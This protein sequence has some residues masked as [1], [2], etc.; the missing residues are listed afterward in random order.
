MAQHFT[1]LGY[2]VLVLD[3]RGSGQSEHQGGFS[4]E[5]MADDI[6]ALWRELG[7]S[8]TVLLGISMGGRICQQL[9]AQA[10]QV[11]SHLILV[12]TTANGDYVLADEDRKWG[13]DLSAIKQTMA[14]YFSPKFL[15][16]NT[17]LVDAMAKNIF[18][19]VSSGSFNEGAKAQDQALRGVDSTGLL[20]AFTLPTL[21][22]HGRDDQIIRCAAAIHLFDHIDDSELLLMSGIGHLLLA[23]CPKR[24]YAEV[25]RFI[26]SAS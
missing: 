16:K 10:A 5:D 21:I 24:L 15:A 14:R 13:D 1:A 8:Q 7:V 20:G 6:E 17:L 4:I 23:E 19:G 11:I 26:S 2:D 9:A 18:S 25:Q 22:I 12:S 3:N